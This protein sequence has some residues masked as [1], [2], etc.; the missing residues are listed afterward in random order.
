MV[1][2]VRADGSAGGGAPPVS[3]S[4]RCGGGAKAQNIKI[5]FLSQA[6]P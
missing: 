6:A 5:G 4:G 3:P 2:E 1:E